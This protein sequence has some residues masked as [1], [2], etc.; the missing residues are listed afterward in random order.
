MSSENLEMQPPPPGYPI[1]LPNPNVVPERQKAVW[2]RK[3]L[4]PLRRFEPIFSA[5]QISSIKYQV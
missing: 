1:N 2:L 3:L 5:N 4:I